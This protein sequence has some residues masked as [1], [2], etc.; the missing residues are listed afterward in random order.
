MLPKTGP[1]RTVRPGDRAEYVRM[2]RALFPDAPDIEADTDDWL[3]QRDAA[4]FVAAR[5]PHEG[6]CGFV[7]VGTRSY[8][9]GCETS[10][11]AYIEGWYVDED[12]RHT[13][14]GRALLEAAEAW[15]R[16]RGHREIASDALLDNTVSHQ[17]HAR[18]GY[19]EV[20]RHVVFRKPL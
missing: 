10:P 18:C 11:V 6:L 16:A 13:G 8:A 14:V 9:E 17:A 3:A 20:E 7:E 1:I 19:R 12:A 4:T 15:A 5:G 2:R